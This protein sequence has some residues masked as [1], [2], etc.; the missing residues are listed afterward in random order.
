MNNQNNR[1]RY[2]MNFYEILL[3]KYK[4]ISR[5]DIERALC[6]SIG[7]SITFCKGVVVESNSCFHLI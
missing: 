5:A 2:F 3:Q 6:L 4:L 1:I 7:I